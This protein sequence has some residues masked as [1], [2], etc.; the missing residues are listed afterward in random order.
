MDAHYSL[1]RAD[2][3]ILGP[4]DRS[5]NQGSLLIKAEIDEKLLPAVAASAQS[6]MEEGEERDDRNERDRQEK[7]EKYQKEFLQLV[8]NSCSSYGDLRK[9]R[10]GNIHSEPKSESSDA[11]LECTI[12][13]Y[14]S[15][16]AIAACDAL[17][18]QKLGSFGP[19]SIEHTW[20]HSLRY[21]RDSV[22]CV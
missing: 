2:V 18:G 10:L 5:K 4:C 15:R 17:R 9:Y 8:R 22:K 16:A 21:I 19:L 14:D 1:P 11:T 7:I 6:E 13:F 3:D 12:E 20:D